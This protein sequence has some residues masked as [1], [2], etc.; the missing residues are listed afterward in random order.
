MALPT[1]RVEFKDHCLRKLGSGV[2]DLEI[3]ETQIQDR[4]DEAIAKYQEYHFDGVEKVYL[5]RQITASIL[6]F[7][8]VITGTFQ[9]TETFLGGT[10]EAE[11]KFIAQ[12]TNNLSVTFTYKSDS[13]LFQD[14][15]IVTGS[16]SGATGTLAASSAVTLGD[17]DNQYIPIAENVLN[18]TKILAIGLAEYGIFGFKYQHALSE[19]RDFSSNELITYKLSTQHMSLIEDLFV[20]QRRFRF[21]RIMNRLF[22]DTN[23]RGTIDVGD[24]VIVE[25]E[26]TLDPE[27]YTEI[28]KDEFLI[29]YATALIK[30]QWANNVKKYA[31]IEL[32]GGLKLNGKDLYDEAV[33]EKKELEEKLETK[34]QLPVPFIMA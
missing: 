24:Y 28:Y 15:E 8:S 10:S 23:W 5:K 9:A 13:A 33:N 29:D 12:A 20:G 21:N 17:W 30:F 4:I 11:G 25:A 26:Q 27:E 1:T 3:S 19:L 32:P 31:E 2:I 7:A 6:T 34:Y 18:V 14:G 22:I 16:E